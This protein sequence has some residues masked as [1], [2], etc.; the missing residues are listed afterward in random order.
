MLFDFRSGR[1]RDLHVDQVNSPA[2]SHDGKYIYFDRLSSVVK[3]TAFIALG[4][5]TGGS[6]RSRHS[7]VS[8]GRHCGGTASDK[9]I[10]L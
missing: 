8:T 3:G 4:R 6:N 5:E 7:T 2:W 9:M 1:W 10:R